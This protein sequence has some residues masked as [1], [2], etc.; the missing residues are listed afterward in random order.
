MTRKLKKM[1]KKE[2]VK[3]LHW[4]V[5]RTSVG[6]STARGMPKK[7]VEKARKYLESLSLEKFGRCHTV[8]S[9]HS[10][11]GKTT[12]GLQRK[13]PNH[14]WG[15]ARKFLNIFLRGIVYHRF[16]CKGYRL[17]HIEPWLEVPL[18]SYVAKGL[19]KD[20]K[21]LDK[22]GPVLKWSGVTDL[23]ELVS[24]D[25]QNVATEVAKH[26]GIHRIHLDLKYWVDR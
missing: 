16:L 17:H 26:V 20:Q 18:D 6:A 2:F 19:K 1:G 3:L 12:V 4:R 8:A 22:S 15:A 21:L 11:L 9:F 7:T 10:L 23:E 24:Q 25:Y 13:L 5:A 14:S